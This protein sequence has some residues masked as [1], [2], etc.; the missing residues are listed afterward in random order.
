MAP[1]PKRPLNNSSSTQVSIVGLGCSSFSSFFWENDDEPPLT[2]D[3]IRCDD[4]RVQEWMETIRYAIQEAQISL[5]D[6]AP[7]Y[8]HGTSEMV[9]GWA[10]EQVLGSS[11]SA[12]TCKTK[13][14]DI[15]VNT[16]V[17]RY[18]GDPQSMFDFSYKTTMESVER[19]LRR[20]KCG[21]IDVLQLHDPEFAPSLQQLLKETIPAM[22]EC[23]A[24]GWCRK[25]G[26]TG[27][28]L[29]VQR[30]I[31][32]AS[33]QE[34]GENPFDQ[35]LTYSHFNL[36]DQSL[37]D[38]K[39]SFGDYV[40]KKNMTLLTAAPLSMGLL[41]HRGPPAWHPAS[42]KLKDACQKAGKLC[43]EQGVNISTLA[44]LVALSNSQIPCTILGMK[45]VDEVKR[46]QEIAG[47][48]ALVKD[49][50]FAD[51][52]EKVLSEKEFVTYRLLQ[53][54]QNGPFAGVW[55]D[56]NFE[57]NGVQQAHEF[58]KQLPAVQVEAWQVH[59]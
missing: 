3:S 30:Q 32:D 29:H 42:D 53:D 24:K 4:P 10:L 56:G 1:V 57:W 26:I 54:R 55:N 50:S 31:I 11:S 39:D 45:D 40:L 37:F 7:W 33:I 5:L 28:P 51:M 20:L 41:T 48:F 25:L 46:A 16:K 49:G 21:Y 17:G 6:T 59:K 23:L 44:I 58:W 52:L 13:R 47:R 18:N 22:K 2:A 27:Y 15:I 9:V 8:G 34:F 14:E 38:T 43:E 36:H 35:S 19:S 12:T